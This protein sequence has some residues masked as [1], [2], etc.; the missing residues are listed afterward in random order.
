L[1]VPA[2]ATTVRARHILRALPC[3]LHLY[4]NCGRISVSVISRP[5]R[6]TERKHNE[7][8]P[9][10]TNNNTPLPI[11]SAG[12]STPKA[13]MGSKHA[14]VTSY[15]L[16]RCQQARLTDRI[17]LYPSMSSHSSSSVNTPCNF[18]IHRTCSKDSEP[19]SFS[20]MLFRASSCR[21]VLVARCWLI[22]SSRPLVSLYFGVVTSASSLSF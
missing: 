19:R 14:P 21:F 1:L 10:L 13:Q 6:A 17:L 11:H 2:L 8:K 22:P 3:H 16:A 7:C 18:N 20:H 15:S 9:K 5:M 12:G 4:S